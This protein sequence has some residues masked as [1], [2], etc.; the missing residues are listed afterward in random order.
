MAVEK[1]VSKSIIER[2]PHFERQ[3]HFREGEKKTFEQDITEYVELYGDEDK[4]VD[5]AFLV[6]FPGDCEPSELYE[7]ENVEERMAIIQYLAYMDMDY[8]PVAR[9]K[10][11]GAFDLPIDHILAYKKALLSSSPAVFH[12]LIGTGDLA[13]QEKKR[14]SQP[15]RGM[16]S[17]Y[18]ERNALGLN[19]RVLEVC[20][21]T[22][23]GAST[24][25]SF[26]IMTII[27]ISR[28]QRFDSLVGVY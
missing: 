28:I 2:I 17:H 13:E 4:F 25:F 3:M 23:I 9:A 26:S 8:E 27:S 1:H 19:Y 11:L 10:L 21:E 20:G 24:L 14:T 16:V 12:S 22:R 18:E 5:Y 15:R 7:H 6:C